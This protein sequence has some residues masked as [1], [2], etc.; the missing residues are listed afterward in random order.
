MKTEFTYELIKPFEYSKS[1]EF[2]KCSEVTLLAPSYNNRKQCQKLKQLFYKIVK[3]QTE[4]QEP[5]NKNKVESDQ[6]SEIEGEDI[7]NLFFAGDIPIEESMDEFEKLLVS[8]VCLLDDSTKLNNTLIGKMS[9]K[10]LEGIF[11]EYMASFLVPS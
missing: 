9:L 8:G 1:G 4:G 10:D 11:G 3:N 2:L 7:V 5:S 6:D